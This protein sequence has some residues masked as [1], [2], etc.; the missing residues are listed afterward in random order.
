MR[1]FFGC[2]KRHFIVTWEFSCWKTKNT[3]N[4]KIRRKLP[5][6]WLGDKWRTLLVRCK[7]LFNFQGS[8]EKFSDYSSIVPSKSWDAFQQHSSGNAPHFLTQLYYLIM[9]LQCTANCWEGRYWSINQLLLHFFLLYI[10]TLLALSASQK[11]FCSLF[12][13]SLPWLLQL[14]LET[15]YVKRRHCF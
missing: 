5:Y 14:G 9:A 1:E 4:S 2:K 3:C 7:F 6:D 8:R 15:T 13:F 11:L 10:A 12:I